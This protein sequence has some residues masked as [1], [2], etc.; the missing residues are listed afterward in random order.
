ML[1]TFSKAIAS[2]ARFKPAIVK[3]SPTATAVSAPRLDFL[4]SYL[5]FDL[6]K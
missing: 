1:P 6:I 3:G 5:N 2:S 4:P